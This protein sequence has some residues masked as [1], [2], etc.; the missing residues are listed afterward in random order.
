M[1]T[2]TLKITGMTCM[3]CSASVKR[4]LSAVEGVSQAAVDL[5]AASAVVHYDAGKTTVD[6]LKKAVIAG[7]FGAES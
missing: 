3:G 7:G 5:G 1:E 6:A 4:L 2:C